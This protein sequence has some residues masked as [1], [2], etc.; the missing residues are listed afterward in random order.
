MSAGE[1]NGVK[2]FDSAVE[3]PSL[4]KQIENRHGRIAATC[5]ISNCGEIDSDFRQIAV[6]SSVLAAKTH[7][8]E[9]ISD[10]PLLF[11]TRAGSRDALPDGLSNRLYE[12]RPRFQ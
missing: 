12:M 9:Q 10:V 1:P 3:L 2:V 6:G 8:F 11:A 7:G 5:S 4:P